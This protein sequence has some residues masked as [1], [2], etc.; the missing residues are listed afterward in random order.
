MISEKDIAD[1]K[2]IDCTK[3]RT[4]VQQVRYYEHDEHQ[5]QEGLQFITELLDKIELLQRNAIKQIP[6]LFKPIEGEQ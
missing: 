4:A 2:A 3:A 5:Y 1:F 6:A